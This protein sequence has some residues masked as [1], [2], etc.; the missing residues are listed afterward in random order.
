MLVRDC[1]PVRPRMRAA[2]TR[3]LMT[4]NI[5][6]TEALIKSNTFQ[7]QYDSTTAEA[8]TN[9]GLVQFNYDW[10]FETANVELRRAL[11]SNPNS[12]EAHNFYGQ[13][14]CAISR[15]DEGPAEAARAIVLDP[16]SPA[17]SWSREQCLLAARR[18][19]QTIA[20]HTKTAELDATYFYYD[21]F[22]AKCRFMP[23]LE[24]KPEMVANHCGTLEDSTHHGNP[25]GFIWWPESIKHS[26]REVC[27]LSSSPA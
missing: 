10:E 16:L 13:Y 23:V 14:L 9:L 2:R 22:A 25:H 27:Q 11:E 5:Y 19:D 15:W 6:A 12:M 17:P 4:A 18:Y 1:N 24:R 20:Q 8:H 3:Y 26:T 7:L 21:S